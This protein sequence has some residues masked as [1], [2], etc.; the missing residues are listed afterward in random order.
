MQI[1]ITSKFLQQFLTATTSS[2]FVCFLEFH[3]QRRR[4]NEFNY[5]NANTKEQ[6]TV[7][8]TVFNFKYYDLKELHFVQILR[9][10]VGATAKMQEWIKQRAYWEKIDES[11]NHEDKVELD[12]AELELADENGT[13]WDDLQEHGQE[14]MIGCSNEKELTIG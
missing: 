2:T 10:P 1:S 11:H 5:E 9:H 8:N 12:E 4:A 7:R 3:P 6:L 14:I 13:E